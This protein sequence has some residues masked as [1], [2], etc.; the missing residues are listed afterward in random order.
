MVLRR[1][2]ERRRL[3]DELLDARLRTFAGEHP[4]P[5]RPW[6]RSTPPTA[7]RTTLSG[8]GAHRFLLIGMFES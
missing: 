6:N 3:R 5:A 4:S 8:D 2:L 7:R 1:P